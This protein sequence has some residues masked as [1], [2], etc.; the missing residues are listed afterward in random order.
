MN[1]YL[2]Y[3][4]IIWWLFDDCSV[5]IWCFIWCFVIIE[6][7]DEIIGKVFNSPNSPL[8]N[9]RCFKI[10][11][12]RPARPAKVISNLLDSSLQSVLSALRCWRWHSYE[13]KDANPTLQLLHLKFKNRSVCLLCIWLVWLCIGNLSQCNAPVWA[14]LFYDSFPLTKLKNLSTGCTA[15]FHISFGSKVGIES[16]AKVGKI[17]RSLIDTRKP[18][19]MIRTQTFQFIAL[20]TS[21]SPSRHKGSGSNMIA[22][23]IDLQ[24]WKFW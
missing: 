17:S 10:P 1:H 11:V 21:P 22:S 5:V 20:Q 12:A 7:F 13:C 8:A 6:L 15:L 14:S 9:L 18:L 23:W 16:A 24:K 4:I 2:T 3:L 19:Q